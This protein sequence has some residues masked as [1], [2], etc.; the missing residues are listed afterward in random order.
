[1]APPRLLPGWG[2]LFFLPTTLHTLWALRQMAG[3]TTT[4]H[5][6]GFRRCGRTYR[7]CRSGR[8][9]PQG[10]RPD[11]DP[12]ASSAQRIACRLLQYGLGSCQRT[13]GRDGLLGR[14]LVGKPRILTLVGEYL[15]VGELVIDRRQAH[16]P[17]K[18]GNPDACRK[19]L[20]IGELVIIETE[21]VPQ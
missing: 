7:S 3:R 9:Q 20:E 12:A 2:C 5:R 19:N 1:M 8:Y 14:F 4:S 10:T 6:H 15:E 18:T 16:L 21:H 17:W 11:R 13:G